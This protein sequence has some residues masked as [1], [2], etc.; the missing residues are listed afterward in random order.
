MRLRPRLIP[1]FTFAFLSPIFSFSNRSSSLV[2]IEAVFAWFAPNVFVSLH[3]ALILIG[4]RSR[5]SVENER[6]QRTLSRSNMRHFIST[7]ARFNI[8]P[9]I[10]LTNTCSK[11]SFQRFVQKVQVF[12]RAIFLSP[13]IVYHP[14]ESLVILSY[15]SMFSSHY[16]RNAAHEKREIVMILCV[17]QGLCPV[18]PLIIILC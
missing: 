9:Q 3:P 16:F 5:E 18:S 13:T 14:L 11:K 12:P 4:Q 2:L 8:R 15:P 17:R 1:F 6:D 7:L 10:L